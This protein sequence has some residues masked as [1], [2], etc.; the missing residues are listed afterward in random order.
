MENF[1]LTVVIF[2]ILAAAVIYLLMA[3]KRGDKCVGCPYAKKCNSSCCGENEKN[4]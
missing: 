4:K 2:A 3:K 1:I